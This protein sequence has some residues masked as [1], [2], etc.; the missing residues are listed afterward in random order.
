MRIA[1]IGGGISG[2]VCAHLLHGKHDI[3]VF[4]GGEYLGG[5]TNT[6]DVDW[7]GDRQSVDTG[8]IVFNEH[9][10]PEFTR[11]LASLGVESKPTTMSLSVRCDGSGLEYCGSSLGG[12]FA[13]RRNLADPG[14]LRMLRDV[15]RFQKQGLAIVDS[16]PDSLTVGAFVA[17]HRYGPEFLRYFLTPMGSALWSTPPGL[18]AQYPIRFVIEFFRNHGMMQIFGR[19]DWRV[20]RGGSRQYAGP[21][22]RGFRERILLREPVRSVRRSAESVEVSTLGATVRFD[23][24]IFACHSDQA[25][26]ILG[27]G[28]TEA[29]RSVLGALPYQENHAVLH[30]DVSVLPRNRRA[31]G[32]WNYHVTADTSKSAA[33]T[34]NMTLLQGLASPHTYC[35]SLN[36]EGID[37]GRVIRRITYHHPQFLPGR[38]AAQR[39]HEELMGPNRTSFCGAYW[40]YGFHEDGVRSAMN[41]CRRLRGQA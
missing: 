13:Q 20:I 36:E 40:G 21:L 14:F 39:R 7:Q 27:A 18:F 22:T 32:C 33:V 12:L 1:I 10:Y 30:T 41:V 37:P 6:I 31:W 35:V 29:E 25:L 9:Y 17:E 19:P 4:E 26:E 2:L 8:F 38:Q 15:V 24:V 16:L 5:H 3:T 28:A 23:H 34:Y 11:L